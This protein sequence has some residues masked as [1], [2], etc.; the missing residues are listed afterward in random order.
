[1]QSLK[2]LIFISLFFTSSYGLAVVK[3]KHEMIFSL[4][5]LKKYSTQSTALYKEGSEYYCKTELNPKFFI[6]KNN[7]EII[8]N[9]YLE[10]LK[11]AVK[12]NT[13]KCGPSNNKLLF[14]F[15]NKRFE[16]CSDYK[17]TSEVLAFLAEDCGRNI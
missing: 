1:M 8:I 15:G 13:V 3:P 9:S 11:N 14:I 16:M 6:V 5:F 17:D 12:E 7:K 10:K 2:Y 4:L